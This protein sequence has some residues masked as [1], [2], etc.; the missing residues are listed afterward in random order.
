MNSL[1]HEDGDD[2]DQC[3]RIRHIV[4][5]WLVLFDYKIRF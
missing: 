2:G 5:A 4:I 1:R 3:E